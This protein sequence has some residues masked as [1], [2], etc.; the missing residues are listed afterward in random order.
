MKRR[1]RATIYFNWLV[2]LIFQRATLVTSIIPGAFEHRL[3]GGGFEVA[4][5][6]RSGGR[7][8]QLLPWRG[9]GSTPSVSL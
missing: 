8:G 6:A 3:V 9:Q 1:Q 7:M 5:G 2:V 4:A